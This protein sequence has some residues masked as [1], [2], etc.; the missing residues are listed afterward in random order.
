MRAMAVCFML[1]AIA[2]ACSAA[3]DPSESG[4]MILMEFF[5]AL[6]D[7]RYSQAA[8]YYGGSYQVLRE[9]NPDLGAESY[10]A[11]WERGCTV[12]GLQCLPILSA[13]FKDRV[14]NMFIYTVEF[15]AID[16]GRFVL[17]PCC[18]ADPASAP[19]VYR[20]EYRVVLDGGKYRVI[21]L[22]PLLP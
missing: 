17:G 5:S 2:V 20:F 12:N 11:L 6:D 1:L 3:L 7:G 14:D 9:M 16:G 10:A 8:E 13:T 15:K 4:R 21:D 19:P 22:P 18:G